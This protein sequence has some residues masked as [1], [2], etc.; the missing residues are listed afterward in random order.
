VSDEAR[1]LG[2]VSVVRYILLRLILC[3]GLFGLAA[4]VVLSQPWVMF[5]MSTLFNVAAAV[6]LVMALS[7]AGVRRYGDK[8][9]FRWS[10][11][12]FD[13]VL[14]TT[15][16]WLSDGPK[17]PFFVLYFMN[18]VAAAWLLPRW[19]AVAVAGIDTVAFT[20]VTA[21][22]VFGITEWEV[23]LGGVLLYTELT[24][25]V[26]SLFLVGMLSGVL[27]GNL[28]RTRTALAASVLVAAQLRAEHIVLLNQ[29]DT[30][31]LFVGE[32][33]DIQGVN[34]AGELLFGAVVGKPVNN[35][36]APQDEVWEQEYGVG[37]TRRI[38]VCRRQH[39]EAGG[40]VFVIEDITNWRKME[41]QVEQDER[42]AAVGRLA[43]GLAHEIRNPLASLSGAVQLMEDEKEDEL[44]GIILR[45]VENLNELVED[46]L[47]IARPL[48]LRTLPTDVNAI[49]S[50]I[51]IAFEQDPRYQGRVSISASGESVPFLA[52]DGNRV[53][54]VIWNLV[55]NAAQATAAEG[56]I[57]IRVRS[58]GSGWEVDVE[59]EGV[60]IPVDHIHRIFDPFYTTRSGGTGLG[61]ANVDRIVRAHNGEVRVHSEV[62]KG[63]CF[64]LR[65]LG[66]AD[67]GSLEPVDGGLDAS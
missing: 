56:R 14:V 25:R 47:D 31:I 39:L 28:Q 26:F 60:G 55:L 16:V 3:A 57:Q 6:F 44:H 5:T 20:L 46:F 34:P 29:L 24:L 63:T 23:M 45:E 52:I 41:Q 43:A 19:G 13:T 40:S 22:G 50:D 2:D 21:A 36:L 53:R 35:V 59:D 62:G 48:Q 10:Q 27:S 67:S 64:T 4:A 66:D 7:A 9:W 18:I 12:L 17:S 11:L 58:F 33:G 65:F 8:V 15:L 49:I 38:L 1:Q 54:Q 37:E 51:V 30:S 61:L 32:D 42:L